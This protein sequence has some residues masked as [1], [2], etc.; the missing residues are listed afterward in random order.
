MTSIG[1][2]LSFTVAADRKLI[3]ANKGQ[4]Q[5][6]TYNGFWVCDHCGKASLD[7][8]PVGAHQRPY[9]VEFAF[10]KPKASK[11]C[12]GTFQ[13]VFLGHIFKTDLLLLRFAIKTPIVTDTTNPV[14]L[15]ALEDSLYSI[16]E[17]LRLAASRHRQLDLD[18]SEFGAGFRIVPSLEDDITFLDVYLYD[19]LSG[20][21]G[22]AD[23]AGRNLAEILDDVQ[24]LLEECPSQCERSCESCLRHYHNQHLKERLDRRVAAQLLR[25]ARFGE[26]P[27]E[28]PIRKQAGDLA[29][30]QR[31]LELDG[32]RCT[33][34]VGSIPVL[35]EKNG[36]RLA[37]GIKSGLLDE[38]WQGHSLKRAGTS[39]I[40]IFN[41]FILRRNLPDEHQLIRERFRE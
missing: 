4:L 41:D 38:T 11:Q 7:Q 34:E 33:E 22:Y 37:V 10:G 9:K 1:S 8:P 29:A 39:P 2:S 40:Q 14:V 24:K 31:L 5:N 17:A 27:A 16:A 28:E 3:T 13:K 18:P 12:N 6:D 20:G 21:A 19:T 25:Y 15:R 30:L 35:I 36:E 23:L 32:F 26:I